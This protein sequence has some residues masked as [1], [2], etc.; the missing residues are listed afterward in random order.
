MYFDERPA[1]SA[2]SLLKNPTVIMLL[3]MGG[4]AVCMPAMMKNMDAEQLREMENQV[5]LHCSA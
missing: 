3:V 5:R 1:F 2:W 4:M